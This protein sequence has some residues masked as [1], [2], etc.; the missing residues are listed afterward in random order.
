V[1]GEGDWPRAQPCSGV[2]FPPFPVETKEAASWDGL[3]EET[4]NW[5]SRTT[6]IAGI[7]VSNWIL[8][9]VLGSYRPGIGFDDIEVRSGF[10]CSLA[11]NSLFRKKYSLFERVGNF[12]AMIPL[13]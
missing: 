6:S 9:I 7:Q 11:A 1:L 3:W 2:G 12:I 4:M 5:F 10:P 8:L 13:A